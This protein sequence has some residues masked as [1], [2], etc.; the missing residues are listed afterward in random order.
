MEDKK[1][2]RFNGTFPTCKVTSIA[3][4]TPRNDFF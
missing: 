4:T 2:S 1:N 3:V